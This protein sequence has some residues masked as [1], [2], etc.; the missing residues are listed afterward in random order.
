MQQNYNTLQP[1]QNAWRWQ[2]KYRY[3]TIH[4]QKNL[5]D[6]WTLIKSWGGLKNRLGNYSIL[7]CSSLDEALKWVEEMDRLRGKRGYGV[8]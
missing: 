3:Y 8:V 5:F 6:E 1:L 7:T 2:S 4:L